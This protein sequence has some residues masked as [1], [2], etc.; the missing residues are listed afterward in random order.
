MGSGETPPPS[1]PG[2]GEDDQEN[3]KSRRA[4]DSLRAHP[5]P[6]PL[7]KP[8][9]VCLPCSSLAR[10]PHGPRVKAEPSARSQPCTQP[11]LV[12]TTHSPAAHTALLSIGQLYSS[13]KR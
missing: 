8:G 7:P 1:P 12:L 5:L 3:N 2:R 9:S 11:L 10:G 4:G 6:Q 13:R